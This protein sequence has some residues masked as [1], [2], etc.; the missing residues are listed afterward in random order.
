M[1]NVIT[2]ARLSAV[3][4]LR[5]PSTSRARCP[6]G[7]RPF[8]RVLVTIDTGLY[9]TAVQC[10]CQ[11]PWFKNGRRG[12]VSSFGRT[13]ITPVKV[14][15]PEQNR[16]LWPAATAVMIHNRH[17]RTDTCVRWGLAVTYNRY[18]VIADSL[19]KRPRN[20]RFT[21]ETTTWIQKRFKM[22]AGTSR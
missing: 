3:A 19:P 12:P 4:R 20:G 10:S 21:S 17:T 1:Y 2:R 16:W 14:P 11:P 18:K 15:T 22:P 7:P 9:L 5:P 6:R 8:P 13:E